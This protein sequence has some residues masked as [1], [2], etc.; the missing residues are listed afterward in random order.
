MTIGTIARTIAI[1]MAPT[2]GTLQPADKNGDIRRAD[3]INVR[4]KRRCDL[5]AG[6]GRWGN[7]DETDGRTCYRCQGRGYFFKD[8]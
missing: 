2:P 6:T 7:L 5:C 4:Q 1:D 3:E 8:E